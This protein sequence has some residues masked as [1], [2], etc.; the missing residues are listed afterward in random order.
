MVHLE[1]VTSEACERCE[2]ATRKVNTVIE[3]VQADIGELEVR[4]RPVAEHPDLVAE[5]GIMS[6]PAVVIDGR[7]V[8]RGVPSEEEL[9]D[10]IELARGTSDLE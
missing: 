8:L 4:E 7:M 9:A 2:V 1:V 10:A 5:H 6:T 3:K